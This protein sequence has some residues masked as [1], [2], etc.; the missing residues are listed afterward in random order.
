MQE[1]S[2]QLA[3]IVKLMVQ[4]EMQLVQQQ[5]REMS[6]VH[7]HLVEAMHRTGPETVNE[8]ITYTGGIKDLNLVKCS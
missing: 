5:Q 7:G 6:Q 4:N 3:E 1:M 8:A 2:K